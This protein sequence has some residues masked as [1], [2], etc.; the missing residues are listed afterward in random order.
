[1]CTY[2]LLQMYIVE[3]YESHREAIYTMLINN[4]GRVLHYVYITYFFRCL[5][6]SVVSLSRRLKSILQK[7]LLSCLYKS[8]HTP[9][10]TPVPQSCEKGDPHSKEPQNPVEESQQQAPS[11]PV[12]PLM[13][14]N[15]NSYG[16][17][18]TIQHIS[19]LGFITL[20]CSLIC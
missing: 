20:L 18:V 15:G 19:A 3:W 8:H 16:V 12:V 4:S 1:M 7:W 6:G 5:K 11:V 17:Q 13:A 10:K 9:K 14:I 2:I